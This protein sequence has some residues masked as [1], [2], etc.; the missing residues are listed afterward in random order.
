M[1]C[2]PW[3]A[4]IEMHPHGGSPAAM[5]QCVGETFLDDSEHCQLLTCSQFNGY[6]AL[7]V[8]NLK[9]ALT[10][11]FHQRSDVADQG[12]WGNHAIVPNAFDDALGINQCVP[13]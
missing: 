2:Q 6:T 8:L 3:A 12:L 9:A 7:T 5:L 4:P 10:H 13:G 11:A 1:K